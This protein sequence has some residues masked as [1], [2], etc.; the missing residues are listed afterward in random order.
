MYVPP[1][2]MAPVMSELPGWIEITKVAWGF[3]T[4]SL[5]RPE[6]HVGLYVKCLCL[7]M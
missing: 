3:L 4:Q 6:M 5:S 7:K 1:L 2:Q